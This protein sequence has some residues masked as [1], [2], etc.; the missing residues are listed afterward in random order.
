MGNNYQYVLIYSEHFQISN[1][2]EKPD[3]NDNYD[4]S[5]YLDFNVNIEQ[6]DID[7]LMPQWQY[8]K[9]LRDDPWK[10][11]DSEGNV[12]WNNVGNW[13]KRYRGCVV[14]MLFR[15]NFADWFFE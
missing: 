9:L 1:L 10:S 15:E 12:V 3:V 7:G 6:A 14:K 13:L 4:G 5:F 8:Q 11:T 2:V